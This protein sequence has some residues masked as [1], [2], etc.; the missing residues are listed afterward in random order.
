[1]EAEEP[2]PI[3]ADSTVYHAP[4][5]FRS[6][7]RDYNCRTSDVCREGDVFARRKYRTRKRRSAFAC[8]RDK[9]PPLI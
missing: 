7:C 9:Q 2:K 5:A 1:M 6:E 8:I 4:A 3:R